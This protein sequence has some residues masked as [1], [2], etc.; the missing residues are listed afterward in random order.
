MRLVVVSLVSLLVAACDQSPEQR[1]T[2]V[3]TAACDCT[4]AL[5]GQVQSC[6]TECID[7]A[8]TT[9]PDECLECVYTFS[10]T[11]A[12]LFTTCFVND[13]PCDVS[14]PQP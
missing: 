7:D 5:P 3:C 4:S 8:P 11:C 13:G 6:I 1:A 2:D 14:D 12:D 9:I 10:Q